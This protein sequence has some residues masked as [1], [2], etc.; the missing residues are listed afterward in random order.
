MYLLLEKHS[1]Q[2]TKHYTNIYKKNYLAMLIQLMKQIIK[3]FG[4]QINFFSLIKL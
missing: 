3:H 4:E 1:R 2:S